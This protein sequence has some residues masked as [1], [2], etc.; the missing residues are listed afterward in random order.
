MKEERFVQFPR[1][2][3]DFSIVVPFFNEVDSIKP[4]YESIV[5]VMD[6]LGHS[7]EMVFVDDGSR[8]GSYKILREI[9]DRDAR[10]ALIRLPRSFGQTAARKPGYDYTRD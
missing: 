9:S 8:D 5:K 7:Y 10:F 1:T 4:L 3:V 6:V 2:S